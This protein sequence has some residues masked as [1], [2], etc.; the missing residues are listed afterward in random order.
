MFG[1][2]D[3]MVS[4]PPKHSFSWYFSLIPLNMALGSIKVVITLVALSLGATLFDIGLIIA[5]NATIGIIFA[6][7]WGRLSDYFGLRIRFLLFF[8]LLSAPIFVLLGLVLFVSVIF[9][10]RNIN[11]IFGVFANITVFSAIFAF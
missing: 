4:K 3:F 5:A 7:S 1:A 2:H 6:I 11:N 10:H 9:S 8:F